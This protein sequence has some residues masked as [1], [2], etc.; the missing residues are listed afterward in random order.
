MQGND[1]ARDDERVLPCGRKSLEECMNSLLKSLEILEAVSQNQPVS[2]G[3]L[4][5]LLDMPKSSVQRVLMT[6][7]EAGWLR[8]TGGDL[9][10]WEVGARILGVR[11]AALRG[12]ALY[13]AARE[14]MR[15]LRELTNE[16]VHLSIPDGTKSMVLIDRA[17]CT[18]TVRTFSPIGDLSPFHATATGLAVLAHMSEAEVDEILG[19]DLPKFSDT[20]PCDPAEIRLELERIRQRGYSIN[21][22]QYRRAV[23]AIGAAIIDSDGAPVG[24][25]CISMPESRYEPKRLKEWGQAVAK[26]AA[27]I[28]V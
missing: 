5:R 24:S 15:E 8:Q 23:C 9:T 2:V 25:I 17:D 1:S 18:Q 7:L 27:A 22:S 14:P 19:R 13:A 16:T 6:F 12:G 10:R 11:P 28:S 20:T 4:A 21:L 26:A 3:V